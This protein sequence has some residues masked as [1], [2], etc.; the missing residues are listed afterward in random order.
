M[1]VIRMTFDISSETTSGRSEQDVWADIDEVV[2]DIDPD[3]IT[4]LK[5]D[6]CVQT[7]HNTR[8]MFKRITRQLRPCDHVWMTGLTQWPQ[9][10]RIAASDLAWLKSRLR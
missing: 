2:G 7:K 4:P 6:R 8:S 9:F 3:Y 10:T 5:S 1:A